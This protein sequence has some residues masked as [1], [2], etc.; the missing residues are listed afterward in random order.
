LPS[1]DPD[2]NLSADHISRPLIDSA[3]FSTSQFDIFSIPSRSSASILSLIDTSPGGKSVHSKGHHQWQ[4]S[5]DITHNVLGSDRTGPNAAA[6]LLAA[7]WSIGTRESDRSLSGRL[8]GVERLQTGE[9]QTAV[10]MGIGL[11]GVS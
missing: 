4:K 6:T 10:S 1:S 9:A 2:P 11:V 5:D 7:A 8:N 3:K